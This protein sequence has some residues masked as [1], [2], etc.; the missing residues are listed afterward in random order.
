M[1]DAVFFLRRFKLCH[2]MSKFKTHQFF[3]YS[4]LPGFIDV[5]ETKAIYIGLLLSQL[6]NS[7]CRL[8]DIHFFFVRPTP[9]VIIVLL[10]AILH[11]SVLLI[12]KNPCINFRQNLKEISWVIMTTFNGKLSIDVIDELINHLIVFASLNAFL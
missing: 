9:V 12:A 5:F 7:L 6:R 4:A 1:T 2:F 3:D 8:G 11:L 10:R